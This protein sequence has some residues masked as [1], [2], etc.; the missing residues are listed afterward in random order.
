MR[1]SEAIAQMQATARRRLAQVDLLLTAYNTLAKS[2]DP[3]KELQERRE[4]VLLSA[5]A[6]M[7]DL[8]GAYE[9]FMGA[10]AINP[11]TMKLRNIGVVE[12]ADRAAD[13]LEQSIE[14]MKSKPQ[15]RA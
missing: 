15:G 11:V 12:S 8:A 2:E 4:T 14:L 9:E 3:G 10:K 5:V 13:S 1:K 6:L 7:S